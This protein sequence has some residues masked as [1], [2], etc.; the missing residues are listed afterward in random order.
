MRNG[1]FSELLALGPQYQIYN[2]FTRRAVAGGR[3]QVDPFPG[4]I[5]PAEPDQ[6]GR[7]GGARVHRPSAVAR[8]RRRHRQLPA[9]VAARDDQSTASNTIRIDHVA[10][11]SAAH[12]R[13]LQLVRSEQQ[14]QQLLQQPLDGRVVPVHLAPGGV[15]SRLGDELVDGDEPALWVQPVR[16]RHRHQSGE[17]RVRSDLAGFPGRSTTARSATTCAGSRASTSPATRAPASAASSVRTRRT[18]SSARSTSRSARIRSAPASS[19]AAT[20]RRRSSSP[21]I[22]PAS[23]SSTRTGPAVRST[24]RRM[25]RAT[26]GQSFAAFLL[27]LPRT[28]RSSG[29]PAT[30]SRP[31]RTGSSS[32]MTGA[33]G[34]G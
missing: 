34:R 4:N 14:L 28:V 18:P 19:S 23:S 21:T 32:R 10:D 1:D 3:F 29:A 7:Q 15:R 12:L 26:L 20:P 8:Q 13:P 6:S 25:H 31:P 11:R 5:I 16:P 33:S 22:R 27:G 30:T 24:I 17:P 2:P 9:A